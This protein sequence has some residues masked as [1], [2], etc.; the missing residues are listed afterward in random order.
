MI[1]ELC[2]GRRENKNGRSK[3]WRYDIGRVELERQ[4][5]ALPAVHLSSDDP[6]GVLYRYPAL[7]LFNKNDRSHNDHAQDENDQG[8]QWR[9]FSFPNELRSEERRVG[10]E[11][12]S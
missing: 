12:R 6:L 10:K 5:R 4:V 3:N 1:R 2:Q 11:E 8:D 9:Q 7:T